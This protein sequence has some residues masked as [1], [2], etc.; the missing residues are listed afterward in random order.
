MVRPF[1]CDF[2]IH[3]CLSPCADLDMYPTALVRE[4]VARRI[5]IIGICDHNA[6]EN[7]PF[8]MRAAEG[9]PLVVFP[10]M[11]VTSSEEV[12]VC[13]LFGNITQLMELQKTVYESLTGVNNENLFGSQVIVNERDEV[14]GY[15]ERLLIGATGLSLRNIIDAVHSL[16]GIAIASH[17]DREYFSV[18]GQ[19]GF[20]PP[21]VGFDALEITC[22]TGIRTARSLYP[23]LAAFPFITSSDAHRLHDIGTGAFCA[24]LDAP[25][26]D[27]L[28]KALTGFD[29][30]KLEE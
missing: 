20:I 25:T 30:R 15:N 12:H 28:R 7:A 6:S 29:G 13:A 19:L 17:I 24:F 8:V 18:L 26:I 16:D 9:T 1:R 27:E 21:D 22:R 3:T 23:E 2:H 11:E 14:E 5:D 4:S 10:G